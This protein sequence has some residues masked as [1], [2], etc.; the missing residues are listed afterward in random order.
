MTETRPSI[1]VVIPTFNRASL[2]EA[3][4]ASLTQQTLPREDYEVVVV[5]DG[6]TDETDAVC[7]RFTSRLR[8][9]YEVIGKSGT[10]SAKNLG[11]FL[12]RAPLV[13]FFDDDDVAMPSMLE[14]HLE[15]HRD[16]PDE[17]IAVLGYTSWATGLEV[18]PVMEYVMEIGQFLFAYENLRDGQILDSSYFWCGRISCKRS[19][20]VSRGVFDPGFEGLEDVELG[21][22]LARFGL[23]VVF[24]RRAAS[25]MNRPVTLD[26]FC[27]RC[28][29]QGRSAVLFTR[30]H[31]EQE[32][33]AYCRVPD[34]FNCDIRDAAGRWPEVQSALEEVIRRAHELEAALAGSGSIEGRNRMLG[35]L[36]ELY[37]WIFHGCRLKGA[38]EVLARS[39]P[40]RRL[41]EAILKR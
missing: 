40:R 12:S 30:F 19:L 1:S 8:L 26:Q 29:G 14:R 5:S 18:T 7:R 39:W 6:S 35:E 11:I 13:F 37:P 38:A 17:G 31:P 22:R 4:L 24:N 16:N 33:I 27:R 25:Q 20:L 2:L 32:A 36:R 9:R 41:S 28:E 10:S 21:Y 15:S 34:P 3:A 23:R